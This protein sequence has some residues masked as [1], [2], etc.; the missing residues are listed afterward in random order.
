MFF[1]LLLM[2]IGYKKIYYKLS[3]GMKYEILIYYT[4]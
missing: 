3:C 2:T 1:F 4:Q